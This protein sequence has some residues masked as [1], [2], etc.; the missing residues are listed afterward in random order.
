MAC[1]RLRFLFCNVPGYYE[2]GDLPHEE[3]GREPSVYEPKNLTQ[4]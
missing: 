3:L 1:G 2:D 4:I